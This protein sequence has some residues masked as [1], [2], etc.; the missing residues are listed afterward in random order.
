MYYVIIAG[1]SMDDAE[2][3]IYMFGPPATLREAHLSAEVHYRRDYN[4]RPNQNVM[5]HKLHETETEEAVVDFLQQ[6]VLF[7]EL[8]KL[9]QDINDGTT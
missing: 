1:K 5:T 4:I 2:C 9:G 7:M 8:K 6:M 3:H